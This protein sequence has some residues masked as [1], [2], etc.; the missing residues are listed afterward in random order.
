MNCGLLNSVIFTLLFSLFLRFVWDSSLLIW[1]SGLIVLWFKKKKKSKI[2]VIFNSIK[3]AAYL[4][5]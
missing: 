5:Y 3:S 2:F 4:M 1:A